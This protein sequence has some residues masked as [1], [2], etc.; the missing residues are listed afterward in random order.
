MAL[1]PASSS[2]LLLIFKSVSV[3]FACRETTARL[4]G[5]DNI[6]A[7]YLDSFSKV[8]DS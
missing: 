7:S 3:E 4:N 6:S 8:L 5:G 2:S 1:P